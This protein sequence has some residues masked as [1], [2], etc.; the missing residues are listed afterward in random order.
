M[1]RVGGFGRRS[2]F[3]TFRRLSLTFNQ[4]RIKLI[5]WQSSKAIRWTNWSTKTRRFGGTLKGCSLPDRVMGVE[6]QLVTWSKSQV[7]PVGAESIAVFGAIPVPVT[8]NRA[9]IGL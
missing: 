7:P 3:R 4:N 5:L 8:L 2:R 6:S 9:R 1:G